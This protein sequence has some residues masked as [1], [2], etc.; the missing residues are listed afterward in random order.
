VLSARPG[1]PMPCF[2]GKEA[3]DSIP[4][5]VRAGPNGRAQLKGI[6]AGEG[7]RSC[8]TGPS[9]EQPSW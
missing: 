8:M 9:P 3:N 6:Q 1:L 5:G 4:D 7:K 2:W